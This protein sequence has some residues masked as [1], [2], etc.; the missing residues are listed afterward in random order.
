ML[1][2]FG[3][4]HLRRIDGFCR[5]CAGSPAH[6]ERVESTRTPNPSRWRGSGAPEWTGV[7]GVTGSQSAGPEFESPAARSRDQ[8][9][10]HRSVSGMHCH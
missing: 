10:H 3:A 6:A 7:T 8:G 2:A 4:V 1:S 9:A 5:R